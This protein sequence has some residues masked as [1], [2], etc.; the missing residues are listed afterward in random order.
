MAQAIGQS[1]S[2]AV[3]VG[4]SAAAIIAV[5]LM[6]G[7]PRGRLTGPMFLAG[8][9]G[10]ILIVG[11]IVL[12]AA[13]GAGA[14]SGGQPAAWVSVLKLVLGLLLLV[15]AVRQWRGR[16]KDGEEPEMPS[17]METIDKFTAGK[18]LVFGLLLSAVN[19]K[20]LLLIVAGAAAIASSG[21]STG[22]EIGSLLVFTLVASIGTGGPVLLYFVLGERSARFLGELKDWMSQN[23]AAIMAVIALILGAKLIGDALAALG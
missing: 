5:V 4:L 17:W 7:T 12:A 9:I 13:G 20:N 16:P 22:A 8:W 19:P 1:L 21:V 15:V 14:S 18:A 11:G 2:F 3:G 6:L 23:N 10:G